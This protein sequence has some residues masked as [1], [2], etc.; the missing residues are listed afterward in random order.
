M[1]SSSQ[2]EH[3]PESNEKEEKDTPVRR[4][5]T[6]TPTVR[7]KARPQTGTRSSPLSIQ[8]YTKCRPPSSRRVREQPEFFT[9]GRR[10]FQ[11]STRVGS[12][13]SLG[14]QEEVEYYRNDSLKYCRHKEKREK[15][16]LRL[17]AG[18]RPYIDFWRPGFGRTVQ[19]AFGW[20]L[21]GL[22]G[23]EC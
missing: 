7:P 23:S 6:P 11:S 8:L 2:P 16:I 21:L 19:G 17:A 22:V 9:L 14:N 12:V 15:K 13:A 20:G 5:S 3:A 1:S 18:G 10:G 4:P